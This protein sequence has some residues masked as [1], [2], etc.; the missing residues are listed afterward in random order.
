M[1][2]YGNVFYELTNAF[3]KFIVKNNGKTKEEEPQTLQDSFN[4]SAIGLNSSFN[5]DS[6]NKWIKLDGENNTCSIYHSLPKSDDKFGSI[7]SW[8]KT[9]GT[10]ENAVVLQPGDNIKVQNLYYDKAGHISAIEDK[11]F[12][13]PI[14]DLDADLDEIKNNIKSLQ[15]N[16]VIQD[17]NISTNTN[18]ILGIDTKYDADIAGLKGKDTEIDQNISDINDRITNEISSLD[19]RI[20]NNELLGIGEN[21]SIVEAIGDLSTTAKKTSV[22]ENL[23]DLKQQNIQILTSMTVTNSSIKNAIDNIC[24][25]IGANPDNIWGTIP[26]MEEGEQDS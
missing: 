24:E 22:V 8:N 23:N 9:E 11:Y 5:I 12:S 1:S 15:D 17:S 20:G 25:L 18:N 10:I 26:G 16:D 19:E 7:D 14:T 21:I 3:A 4:I 2:F 6:G 13:L